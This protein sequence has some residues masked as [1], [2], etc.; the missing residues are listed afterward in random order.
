MPGHE[1][2]ADRPP[3]AIPEDAQVTAV[4]D[5][6]SASEDR[7]RALRDGFRFT[8]QAGIRRLIAVGQNW[9]SALERIVTI[10]CSRSPGRALSG[11]RRAC[12]QLEI[13]CLERERG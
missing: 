3:P 6:T 7:T 2:R 5:R 8:W 10:C 9:I 4:R 13:E 1:L 12:L 11:S